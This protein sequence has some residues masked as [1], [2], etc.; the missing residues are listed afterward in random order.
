[1]LVGSVRVLLVASSIS[2]REVV[3]HLLVQ[4]STPTRGRVAYLTRLWFLVHDAF[5]PAP[6]PKRKISAYHSAKM[7]EMRDALVSS[8][9]STE[10]FKKRVEDYEYDRWHRNRRNQQ[11]DGAARKKHAEGQQNTED[12]TR[13]ADGRINPRPCHQRDD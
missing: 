6:V 4:E 8:E 11:D 12:P 9:N 10:Q 5:A 3:L 7:R 2:D 1:M 13:R